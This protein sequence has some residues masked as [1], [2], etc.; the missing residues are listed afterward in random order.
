MWTIEHHSEYFH[1][2]E[3]KLSR[4][5]LKNVHLILAPLR[6]YGDFFWYDPA[7]DSLP[8]DFRLVVADGPPGDVK[9]GRFDLLPML[10]RH[11]APEVV[12]L[13]DEAEREQE[14]AVLRKWT[15]EYSLALL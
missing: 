10:P 13:L 2:T 1:R 7:V 11:F 4:F 8:K 5:G 12:N 3:A 15:N 9:G 6:D 14:R